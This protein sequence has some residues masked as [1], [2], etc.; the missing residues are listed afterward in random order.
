MDKKI[1]ILKNKKHIKKCL[2]CKNI[3][4]KLTR[5]LCPLCYKNEIIKK[6]NIKK[7]PCI[8]NNS[9]NNRKKTCIYCN[10]YLKKPTRKKNKNNTNSYECFRCKITIKVFPWI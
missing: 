10:D 7:Y 6:N 4:N 9:L 8:K 3:T 1:K 2:C 5:G